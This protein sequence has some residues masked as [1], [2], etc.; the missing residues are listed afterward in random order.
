ML[1]MWTLA[2]ATEDYLRRQKRYEKK[3]RKQLMAV[4]DNL[5][6]FMKALNDGLTLEQVATFGF[7]HPEPHGVLAIDQKGGGKLAQTRLYIYPDKE[8]LMAY[9]VTLG[10]KGSQ[11]EDIQ[12]CNRFVEQV[13]AQK[14]MAHEPQETL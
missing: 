10:D 13:R 11:Q 5:D 7:V 1:T 12:T 6:T 8:S 3:K 4:L 14:G 9:R 2:E